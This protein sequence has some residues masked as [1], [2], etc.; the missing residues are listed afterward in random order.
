MK[1][2]TIFWSNHVPNPAKVLVLLEELGLPYQ[3]SFVKLEDL[4]KKPFEDINPNGRLP[5]IIDPNNDDITLFES[6]AIVSY[7]I[8]TYD[9]SSALTYTSSPER[10]QLQQWSYFQASGQGPYFG[11]AAW[12]NIFHPE[13]LPSA[14]ERY[15]NEIN[16]VAGVLDAHLAN[17]D[18]LV[19]DKCTYADLS[20]V[21]WNA[22]I[23]FILKDAKDAWDPADYPYFTR[24]QDAML[25]RHSVKHVLSV[26]ANQE[27][28][29]DGKL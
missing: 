24:W 17:R 16:R 10:F 21:M 18:W 6:G 15:N 19:G 29:S 2:I 8:A 26:M 9:K 12:F 25:A 23:A 27:V 1:P 5:A 22:Q 3:S 14:R 13:P 4:K 7:L 28:K 11:Q 20:F